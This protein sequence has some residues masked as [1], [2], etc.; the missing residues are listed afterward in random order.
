MLL[1]FKMLVVYIIMIYGKREDEFRDIKKKY[2]E[3][4]IKVIFNLY[5]K[6]LDAFETER[7]DYLGEI[8]YEFK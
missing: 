6:L 3:K 7:W 5:G 8:F 1:L 4:E 2:T